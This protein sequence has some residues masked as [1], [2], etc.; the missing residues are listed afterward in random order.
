MCILRALPFVAVPIPVVALTI[1]S[2]SASSTT[3]QNHGH[4][5]GGTNANEVFDGVLKDPHFWQSSPTSQVA[6]EWIQLDLK[7]PAVLTQY[8]LTTRSHPSHYPGKE[9]CKD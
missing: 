1:K 9:I 3:G 8:S 5:S 7:S 4:G 2:A 6:R